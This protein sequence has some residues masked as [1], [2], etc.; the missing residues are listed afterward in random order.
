MKRSLTYHLTIY[1]YEVRFS[2]HIHQSKQFIT[3]LGKERST[4]TCPLSHARFYLKTS[5]KTT[6]QCYSSV[7]FFSCETIFT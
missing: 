6:E 4:R 1:L 3:G 7:T 2:Q 5:K